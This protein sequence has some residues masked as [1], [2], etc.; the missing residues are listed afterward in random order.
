MTQSVKIYT[1]QG[2]PY[3]RKA[4]E[5]LKT[6]GIVFREVDVT[7]DPAM[8]AELERRTGWLTVPLVFIGNVFAGGADDLEELEASGKLGQMLRVDAEM[9]P[10]AKWYYRKTS[11]MV[12]LLLLGP[13]AFP[14]LWKSSEYHRFWKIFLTVA[15]TLLTGFLIIGTWKTYTSVWDEMKKAGLI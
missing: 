14:L 15:F 8:R 5:I 6:K 12:A 3:C 1:K 2:C 10:S 4:A 7:N 9:K 11:V 13:A